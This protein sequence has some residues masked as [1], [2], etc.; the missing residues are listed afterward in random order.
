MHFNWA[1]CSRFLT[2]EKGKLTLVRPLFSG[3]LVS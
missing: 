2:L 1:A 3:R